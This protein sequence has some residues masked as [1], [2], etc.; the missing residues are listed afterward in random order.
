MDENVCDL[1]MIIQDENDETDEN[2]VTDENDDS[3]SVTDETTE[4]DSESVTDIEV[5]LFCRPNIFLSEESIE[6]IRLL[7][8]CSG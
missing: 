4:S 1:S 6:F 2:D 5:G 8:T 7:Q 3:S